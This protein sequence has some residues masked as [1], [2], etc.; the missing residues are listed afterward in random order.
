MPPDTNDTDLRSLLDPAGAG[1]EEAV[2]RVATLAEQVYS[3]LSRGLLMGAWGPDVR[4][5]VRDLAQ[6]LSV[7]VTPVREAMNRLVNEGALSNADG[8]GFWTVK[9]DRPAYQEIMRIRIALEPVA[10]SLAATRITET[11]L[12]GLEQQNESLNEAI[13]QDNFAAALQIDTAF[14]LAIYEKAGQPLL[15]SMISSL[16][17][18]AGPTRT[19]LSG[20]YRKTLVGFAHHTRIL[21]A[22]RARDEVAVS[23]EI[24][25]DLRDGSNAILTELQP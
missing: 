14:H 15:N 10:A 7:S 19:R 3:I 5:S 23:T 22:L 2:Q 1:G 24:A 21:D 6:E 9:L 16:L 20:S 11:E 13:A 8:R 25:A 18:R 12:D 17:L 4:L